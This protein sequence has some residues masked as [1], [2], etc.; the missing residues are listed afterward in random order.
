MGKPEN[1]ADAQE[2]LGSNLGG[3]ENEQ[4]QAQE[5]AQ[6][7]EQAQAEPPAKR[8]LS[9]AQTKA[10]DRDENGEAGGSKP[11]KAKGMPD[12][13][14]IILEENDDI[15][16]T[17]LFVSHNGKPYLIRTGE[18]VQVPNFILG[19]L[20][21]AI[22]TVAITDPTSRRVVGHRERMRYSYRRVAAPSDAE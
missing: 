2:Q 20:D 19:I 5:P 16:P 4:D 11:R 8:K 3:D 13:T 7:Q 18:P 14:W 6:E 21:D 10:L 17:G 22:M 12:R 9:A 15:P 1:N